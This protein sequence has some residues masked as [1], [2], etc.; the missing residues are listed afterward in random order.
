MTLTSPMSPAR[1]QS[2]RELLIREAGG[3]PDQQPRRRHRSRLLVVTTTAAMSAVVLAA[4]VTLFLALQRTP[5]PTGPWSAVPVNAAGPVTMSS[6]DEAA[7][8]TQCDSFSVGSIVLGGVDDDPDRAAARRILVDV[9]GGYTFCVDIAPGDGTAA[10]PMVAFAGLRGPAAAE[11]A[12][13]EAGTGWG[14]QAMW[15]SSSDHEVLSPPADD[16]LVMFG[17]PNHR[18]PDGEVNPVKVAYGPVGVDVRAVRLRLSDGTEVTAT[19][20]NGLWGAWWPSWESAAGVAEL[21][22]TTTSGTR[23]I[24]P[25]T[26][27]YRSPVEAY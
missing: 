21:V 27:G 25:A 15:G 16:S 5:M 1:H 11:S 3:Q 22:V 4:G 12:S 8:G 19:V 26:V 23:V 6:D 18:W 13:D 9:R 24:D 14:G 2:V 20:A 10:D 17:D 7:W